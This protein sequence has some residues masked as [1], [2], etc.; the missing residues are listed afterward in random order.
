MVTI[1]IPLYRNRITFLQC[2]LN[3]AR[4]LL[5]KNNENG[6]R[7][8]YGNNGATI[9]SRTKPTMIWVPPERSTAE[10][11][12]EIIH[13]SMRILYDAGVEVSTD[14]HEALTYLFTFIC[15]KLKL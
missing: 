3:E 9:Y 5:D 13:A 12:H 14:N 4:H 1:E 10:L 15:D 11:C 6:S 7:L 8:S 2:P